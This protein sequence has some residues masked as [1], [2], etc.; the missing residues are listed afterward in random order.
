MSWVDIEL[1]T[2]NNPPTAEEV[3]QVL[4]YRARRAKA[5]FYTDEH[6]PTRAVELL[7]RMGGRVETTHET[8]RT[9]H[10][11]EGHA[12]YALRNGL[13]LLTCDRDFL[14][15]RRFP[16]IHCPAI[17]VFDFGSGSVRE[18]QQA[19]RCLAGVFRTPQFYDKW[20]KVDAQRDCW[21][22]YVRFQNGTTSR[23][24]FRL[25]RGRLQEWI[26]GEG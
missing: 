8:R 25:W 17:F 21:T 15:N 11:D 4:L 23:S 16:L 20:W 10:P 2:A 19:F 24:R 14:D 13:V 3:R 9:G 7:R 22:E 1:L 5:R 26:E 18:M 12:A 6:F